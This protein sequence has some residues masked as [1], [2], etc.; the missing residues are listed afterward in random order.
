M[1]RQGVAYTEKLSSKLFSESF[2]T[3]RFI[4]EFLNGFA[5]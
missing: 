3:W 2:A 4:Y 5:R 1:N